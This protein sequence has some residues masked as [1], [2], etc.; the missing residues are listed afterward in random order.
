MARDYHDRMRFGSGRAPA[1]SGLHPLGRVDAEQRHALHQHAARQVCQSDAGS[2]H[3]RRYSF[4]QN[5]AVV[6]GPE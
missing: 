1:A 5:G 2:S 3:F 6:V 4:P